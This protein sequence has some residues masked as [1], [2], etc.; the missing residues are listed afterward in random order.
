MPLDEAKLRDRFRGCLLGVAVGDA[1]GAPFEGRVRVDAADVD[2]WAGSA[3]PLRWTDDT[4]MTIGLARSLVACDGFD[5]AHLAAEFARNY[6]AEPWRGYGAGPPQVF[7]ALAAGSAWDEPARKLFGGQ[8]SFG[9]GAAMRVAPVGLVAHRAFGTLVALARS[10]ARVTH[11]HELGQ[12]AAAV[13]WLVTALPAPGWDAA[14]SLLDALRQAAPDTAFQQQLD[15]VARIG[16]AWG[17]GEVVTELG[18]DIA[19]VEAVPAALHAFLRHP[20]SLPDAVAYA[21]R[22]GGDTDTIASMT[23]ALAGAFLGEAALPSAW[24]AR[25]EAVDVLVALA[26]RLVDLSV[27]AGTTLA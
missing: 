21:V 2:R 14:A 11:A 4:H 3:M 22:L 9:N 17:V 15:R 16:G 1:L 8:G 24:R 18:N 20:L 27:R 6:H 13:G 26:D 7:A 25:L 5:G 19:G 12:Q 23:G 10:S